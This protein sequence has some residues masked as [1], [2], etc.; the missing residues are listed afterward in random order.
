M[1]T[2]K[3]NDSLFTA[4]DGRFHFILHRTDGGYPR[5]WELVEHGVNLKGLK[6]EKC[7]GYF[8]NKALAVA[9]AEALVKTELPKEKWEE[10]RAYVKVLLH[11]G[12]DARRNRCEDTSKFGWGTMNGDWCAAYGVL[13]GLAVLGYLTRFTSVPHH[14]VTSIRELSPRDILSELE[15]EVLAEE[16]FDGDGRCEHCLKKYGKDD[17][18]L[19]E[20]G[21]A[22]LR[23]SLVEVVKAQG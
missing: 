11:S 5:E 22:E 2:T 8:K 3:V 10:I 12:R 7:R 23:K 20:S 16:H 17:R 9:A 14:E 19:R 1:L 6:F 15:Q 4:L 21:E 18:S 13:D